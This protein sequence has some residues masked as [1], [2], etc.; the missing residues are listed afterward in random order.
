MRLELSVL[1][2]RAAARP[3]NRRSWLKRIPCG[4]AS[5]PEVFAGLLKPRF[6]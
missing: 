2:N 1:R 4:S 3:A 6:D 5:V